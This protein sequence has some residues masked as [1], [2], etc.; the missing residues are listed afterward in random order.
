MMIGRSLAISCC[1]H[2]CL[3]PVLLALDKQAVWCSSFPHRFYA[4][5]VSLK[6]V[7]H[8]TPRVGAAAPD[9]AD[10]HPA[11]RTGHPQGQGNT[12][13]SRS[14]PCS[15]H[16][17]LSRSRQ[18]R[19][20][21]IHTLQPAQVTLKARETPDP[22]DPHPAA[23]TGHSQGQGSTGSSRSAPDYVQSPSNSYQEI[24]GVVCSLTNE[25]NV[26]IKKVQSCFPLGKGIA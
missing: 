20:Q 4:P 18:H 5:P 24:S 2:L 14:A 26:Q 13:S 23:L 1:K 25:C 16:R 22:A 19:I 12:G 3:R 17:S 11:A 7:L 9:P 21:Q 15:P 8:S 10:P 6:L